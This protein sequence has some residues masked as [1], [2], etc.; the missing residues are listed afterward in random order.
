[1]AL[2]NVSFSMISSAP[3]N[4]RD[5]GAV[6]DGTTNDTAAINAAIL[7]A[8]PLGRP[9]YLPAGKYLIASTIAID[10]P[11]TLFG[12][13]ATIYT[14]SSYPYGTV[15]VKGAAVVGP[16]LSLNSDKCAIKS[17]G[18]VGLAGNTG[19]GIHVKA[20]G[21][22]LENIQV[23]YA[24]NDGVRI[25]GYVAGI[26]ANSCILNN[27]IVNYNGG[28]GLYI[29]DGNGSLPN[30]NACSITALSANFN[31]GNGV[32]LG[33][34]FQNTFTGIHIEDNGAWGIKLDPESKNNYFFGGDNTETNG[35]GQLWNRGASNMFF[36]DSLPTY[37]EAGTYT[38][39]ITSQKSFISG[40][41]RQT[42]YPV[43]QQG[44]ANY[45]ST[46]VLVD[47]FFGGASG[48]TPVTNGATYRLFTCSMP[49][50]GNFLLGTLYISYHPALTSTGAQRTFKAYA[51][52]ATTNATGLAASKVTELVD[53]SDVDSG[54][55]TN[56]A[57]VSW[58]AGV[59]TVSNTNTRADAAGQLFSWSFIGYQRGANNFTSLTAV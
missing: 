31:T 45:F 17:L 38:V 33:N 54:S 12:D 9:V 14:R 50:N 48:T 27:V 42:P 29:H 58:S 37:T 56:V 2:T 23:K 13:I 4:V 41:I 21:C 44:G 5:F 25:G 24:G 8:G 39:A 3:I 28:S 16:A 32:L 20:N 11:I 46:Q 26:N 59:L 18:V 55:T 35:S 43:S 30:A 34:C 19:D 15:I 7:F 22:L 1:M 57:A 47:G 53:Y 6:G 52:S 40:E 49:A 10:Y 36:L 51:I